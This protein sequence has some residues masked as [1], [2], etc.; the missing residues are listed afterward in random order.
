MTPGAGPGRTELLVERAAPAFDA[1]ADPG[2]AAEMRRYMRDRFPFYGVPTPA[3]RAITRAAVA[4]LPAPT[5]AD[6]SELA[7]ACWARDEREWQYLGCDQ[8]RRHVRACSARFLP[9]A[10]RLITTRSWWDTVDVLAARVVGPLVAATPSLREELEGWVAGDDLWL[11]RAAILHQLGAKE[12]TDDE[13]LFRW[14]AARAGDTDFFVRKAIGWALRDYART[15]PD[16]VRR[17]VAEHDA[18]LSGL[19]KREALKHLRG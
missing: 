4:G 1:A 16:A 6:L 9:V 12:R 11:T 14:C 19:S 10:Q 3:R 15:D 13:L 17:F 8:L 5:E 18:E 2:R 7:D